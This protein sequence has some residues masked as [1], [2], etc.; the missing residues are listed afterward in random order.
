MAAV[1]NFPTNN[2]LIFK[3]RFGGNVRGAKSKHSP[4]Q[5]FLQC[6]LIWIQLFAHVCVSR[7]FTVLYMH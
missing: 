5:L 1:A 4:P 3:Y 6:A 7:I 2:I